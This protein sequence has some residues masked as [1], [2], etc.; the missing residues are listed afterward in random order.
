MSTIKTSNIQN[1]SSASTNI[2]L[3][4]DGSATFAQMPV[5]PSYFAM[6]N[7]IINGAMDIDQR[8]TA[9]TST[10]YSVDRWF[11]SA[12]Q[13]SK[14]TVQKNA[15]SITPPVGYQSYLGVTSSSAY[16]VTGNEAFQLL[17]IIE[18]FNCADF[19]WGTLS[20][21]TATLSFWVYSSLTGTFGGS[22]AT[23]KTTVWVMPFTYSVP[24]ANTWTY[25]TIAIPG[26]ASATPHLDNQAGIYVRFGLGSA[27]TSSGGTAGTWT[28]AGNYIQPAGTVSVVG[29]NGATFYLTGC[30]FEVGNVATPYERRL[31]NQE[32]AMCQRYYEKSYSTTVTPGTA[33][34]TDGQQSI[35]ISGASSF[36][37]GGGSSVNFAVEKRT[38]PT[39]TTYS[40]VTGASG[41][42]RDYMANA[43]VN[44]T[45]AYISTRGCF[46][47]ATI[48]QASAINTYWQWVASAEI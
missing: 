4:T 15:G 22:I 12:S 20:P 17:Q 32:L 38:P 28:S 30:Q 42:M 13:P 27:G 37:N 23:A 3:N 39:V 46:G 9:V 1:G 45:V 34:A 48:T 44:S 47:Y 11:Y 31:I 24:A 19:G 8:N 40:G 36:F 43:D 5:G 33:G 18:G 41:K 35:Y 16:S 14:A 2:V 10:N 21:K 7:K 25:V 29:T 6:R 26:S